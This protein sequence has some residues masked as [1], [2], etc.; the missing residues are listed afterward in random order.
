MFIA[1]FGAISSAF[2][3]PKIKDLTENKSDYTNLE[4]NIID[5]ETLKVIPLPRD[6]GDESFL[7]H[8][9]TNELLVYRGPAASFGI[10]TTLSRLDTVIITGLVPNTNWV[11]IETASGKEGFVFGAFLTKGA[12]ADKIESTPHPQEEKAPLEDAP[13]LPVYDDGEGL[14]Q[15][16]QE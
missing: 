1:L 15:S 10:I 9:T 13:P 8:V 5:Q 11:R 12:G 7:H 16:H 14:S 4:Q 2:L 6:K 3:L